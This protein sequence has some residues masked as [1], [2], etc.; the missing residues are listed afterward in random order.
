MAFRGA[1]GAGFH[2]GK[3]SGSDTKK[4]A[5]MLLA[6]FWKGRPLKEGNLNDTGLSRGAGAGGG[7][8][9]YLQA[10]LP[11]CWWQTGLPWSIVL[12]GLGRSAAAGWV[13]LG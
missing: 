3:S 9:G 11:W 13:A 6:A 1:R 2:K 7:V 5:L 12:S 10:W 8:V 4:Q